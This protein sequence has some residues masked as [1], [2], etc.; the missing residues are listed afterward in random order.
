MELIR[1]AEGGTDIDPELQ[2]FLVRQLASSSEL[3]EELG[4]LRKDLYLVS[5]QI[6]EYAISSDFEMELQKLSELCVQRQTNKRYRL[7]NFL[8]GK[9]FL[10]LGIGFVG[11]MIIAL[12]LIW[13]N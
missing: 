9:E 10:Y 12:V 3:R 1:F 5:C 6:P 13:W 8:M 7:V 2:E 4:T 11:M